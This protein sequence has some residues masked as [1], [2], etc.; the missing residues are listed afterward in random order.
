MSTV[1]ITGANR[2]I[3]LEL[4]RK[5][6]AEGHD[7]IATARD[8]GRADALKETGAEVHALDIADPASVT[9]LKE[10]LG[11][12]PIDI[13]VNNAGVGDFADLSSVDF[14][15]FARILEVNTIAPVRIIRTFKDNVLAGDT[16]LIASL[17]SNMGSIENTTASYGLA[18]RV[19]KAGLNM[20]LRAAATELADEGITLLTL[21]PGWVQTDMGG[22][23]APVKPAESAAGLYRVIT[24]A[25]PARELRFLD[26]EGHTRPW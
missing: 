15:K 23:N 22:E 8:P 5:F 7:V 19:S 10:T 2:G 12:R 24:S 17:S 26:F 6:R 16:R 25:E 18:Y 21:H 1:M 14:D 11:E 3:G 13:L 20:A 4:A 9:A